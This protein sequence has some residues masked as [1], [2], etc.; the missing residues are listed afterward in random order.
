MEAML[1]GIPAIGAVSGG[2]VRMIPDSACGG[3]AADLPGFLAELDRLLDPESYT[4]ISAAALAH[5]RRE[6]GIERFWRDINA[7]Y[8]TILG[9]QWCAGRSSKIQEA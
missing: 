9:T 4:A 7:E 3:K 2:A 5:A 8:A 1:R 6:F